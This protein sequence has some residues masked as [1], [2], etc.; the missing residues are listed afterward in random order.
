MD[1]GEWDTHYCTQ[2]G[3]SLMIEAGDRGGRARA[4]RGRE[5]A[6]RIR[7]PVNLDR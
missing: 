6:V 2:A 5:E 1:P 3:A 4:G 7:V